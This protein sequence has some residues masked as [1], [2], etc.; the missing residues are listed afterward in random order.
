M[1]KNLDQYEKL[2]KKK[3]T[4]SKYLLFEKLD[5]SSML[6]NLYYTIQCR[7]SWV[8]WTN[9]RYRWWPREMESCDVWSSRS[10]TQVK[11]RTRFKEGPLK[12]S[13]KKVFSMFY[14]YLIFSVVN[15][16][17][18]DLLGLMILQKMRRIRLMMLLKNNIASWKFIS[19]CF[20]QNIF[21]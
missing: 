6:I 12:R 13:H 5:S 1:L 16:F 15:Q 2:G 18:F 3:H 19:N 10:T 11:K 17:L 7:S 21:F 20:V 9:K 4:H 8:L 14:E